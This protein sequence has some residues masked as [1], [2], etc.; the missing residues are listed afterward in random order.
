MNAEYCA[1]TDSLFAQIDELRKELSMWK[2]YANNF[3]RPHGRC[4]MCHAPLNTGYCCF[5]CGADPTIKE[6][7]K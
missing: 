7:T 1:E 4:K 3:T 5:N 2:Q 6:E